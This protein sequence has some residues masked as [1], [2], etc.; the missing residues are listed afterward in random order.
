MAALR[1]GRSPQEVLL[2]RK[3]KR[4]SRQVV[5]KRQVK[6]E[7]AREIHK[8]Q[9][10]PRLDPTK[11]IN[12]VRKMILLKQTRAK[13]NR[14]LG[15]LINRS[16]VRGE[17]LEG[18]PHLPMQIKIQT[19]RHNSKNPVWI[20]VENQGRINKRGRLVRAERVVDQVVR[21]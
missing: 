16:Q 6:V 18:N 19:K 5:D 8:K 9:V 7:E 1:K 10:A 4:A 2:I 11:K 21:E 12:L 17:N 15:R 20:A 13:K 3:K 14:R